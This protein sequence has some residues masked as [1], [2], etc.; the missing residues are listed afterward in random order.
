MA[1]SLATSIS[2][3]E[4]CDKDDELLYQASQQYEEAERRLE[5]KFQHMEEDDF[6][7]DRLLPKEASLHEDEPQHYTK[8]MAHF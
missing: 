7:L 3:D 4:Y 8:R 1:T 5:E 2:D 6:G